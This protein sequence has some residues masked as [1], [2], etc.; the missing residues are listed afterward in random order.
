[1]QTIAYIPPGAPATAL[2]CAI[3]SAQADRMDR[4]ARIAERELQ[5][6]NRTRDRLDYIIG[7][8]IDRLDTIDAATVDLEHTLGA[9][10]SANRGGGLIAFVGRDGRIA[11]R[12]LAGQD[13]WA[14]GA[15]DEREVDDEGDELDFEEGDDKPDDE[16][17]LGASEHGG[18]F[19]I[20]GTYWNGEPMSAA[21]VDCEGGDVLDEGEEGS[22][23]EQGSESG[24]LGY[25]NEDRENTAPERAGR[26]FVM[27]VGLDD[28][29]DGDVDTCI[30]DRHHDGEEGV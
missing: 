10:E 11:T 18:Y 4:L 6:T 2:A 16:P 25:G 17:S 28:D 12:T 30:T 27:T 15:G 26:G 24:R 22:W 3:L 13:E 1:M 20:P 21:A 7:A 23:S 5:K 8:L 19:G 14:D 9:P 29:E